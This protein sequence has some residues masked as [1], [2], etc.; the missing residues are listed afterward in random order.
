MSHCRCNVGAQGGV[1]RVV[2]GQ[3]A[4]RA[5]RSIV[6]RRS[7]AYRSNHN[8]DRLGASDPRNTAAPSA[9]PSSATVPTTTLS[10]MF[11]ALDG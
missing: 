5:A 9:T 4:P 7:G 1:R 3:R 8:S 11:T 6:D 10:T 2:R